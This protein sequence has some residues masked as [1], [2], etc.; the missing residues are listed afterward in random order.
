MYIGFEVEPDLN[1]LIVGWEN[2]KDEIM[3]RNR[4]FFRTFKS[5]HLEKI[6]KFEEPERFIEVETELYRGWSCGDDALY[7]I[8]DMGKPNLERKSISVR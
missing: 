2:F 5:K 3:Y 7:T 4:F 6:L 1:P 8:E